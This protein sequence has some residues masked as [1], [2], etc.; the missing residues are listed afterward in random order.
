[1]KS[2]ALFLPS[3]MPLANLPPVSG[4]AVLVVL[5]PTIK[6]LGPNGVP[7]PKIAFF[8]H[9]SS[10][11]FEFQPCRLEVRAG[12]LHGPAKGKDPRPELGPGELPGVDGPGMSRAKADPNGER[13]GVGFVPAPCRDAQDRFNGPKI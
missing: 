2:C 9:V 12:V 4:V 1:M 8:A 5:L 7:L 6:D 11:R 10:P 3:G 13:Q